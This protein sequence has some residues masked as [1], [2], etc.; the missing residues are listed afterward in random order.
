ML[1]NAFGIFNNVVPR[2]QWAE[3]DLPFPSDDG[4][5]KVSSYDQ[6]ITAVAFPIRKMKIKEAFLVLFSPPEVNNNNLAPLRD[7][8]L[9]AH[10][11]QMLIHCT[12]SVLP[13]FSPLQ[14]PDTNQA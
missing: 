12:L 1:D 8:N 3:I 5:F 14:S 4:Y 9:T 13:L 11:M 2:I 10:D 6:F 7:G